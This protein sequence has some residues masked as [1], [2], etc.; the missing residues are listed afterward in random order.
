MDEAPSNP[1]QLPPSAPRLYRSAKNRLLG[2]VAG[3]LAERFD[4]DA[5]IVRVVFVVLTVLWGLGA[6]IYLVM[7][8]LIPRDH[9]S[10]PEGVGG[11]L[12]P[13][14]S[15]SSS[16]RGPL[17][18]LLVGV[19]VVVLV[20]SS[21]AGGVPQFASGLTTMWLIFLIIIAILALRRPARRVS[22]ARVVATLFLAALSVVILATG[23]VLAFLGSTGVALHGGSGVR[24]WQPTSLSQVSHT[25]TTEFGKATVDLSA[26][27][28]PSGGYSV[29]TSVAAGVLDIVV[30]ANAVVDLQTHVGVGSVTFPTA[31]GYTNYRQFVGVPISLTTAV[32][33]SNAPHLTLDVEVGI[34]LIEVSR[35]S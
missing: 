11:P 14:S 15:P 25:Y 35:A 24:V 22:L 13:S 32:S 9:A 2:G 16:S 8:V 29:T 1:T 17:W 3:G 6:A 31:L 34:G 26:V 33:R 4:I 7:W 18:A 27:N 5:N 28:F 19:V 23:A 10:S 21:T 12:E 30:P 20:F